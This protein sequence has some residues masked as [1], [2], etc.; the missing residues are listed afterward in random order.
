MVDQLPR[1]DDI[2]ELRESVKLLE[3]RV[4]QIERERGIAVLQPE[5]L[6]IT[7]PLTFPPVY[8]GL[9]AATLFTRVAILSFVLMGALIL[10]VLTERHILNSGF[11]TLLG[12]VYAVSLIILALLPGR[13]G[14]LARATSIFQCCGVSLAFCIALESSLR[15]HTFGR[16]MAMALIAG[17][18]ALTLVVS[19]FMRKPFLAAMTLVGSTL[20]LVGLGLESEGLWPQFVLL[21]ALG[22]ATIRLSWYHGWGFLRPLIL[23]PLLFLLA[24]GFWLARQNSLDCGPLLTS[25]ILLWIAIV[26]QHAGAFRRLNWSATLWLPLATAWLA[27]LAWTGNSQWAS[28]GAAAVSV[29]AVGAL[30]MTT[31]RIPV[32]KAGAA[33]ITVTAA[34]AG[35]PGW[36]SLD[37]S[38]VLCALVGV[39]LWLAAD[40]ERPPWAVGCT[41]FLLAASAIH[42]TIH[43]IDPHA[44]MSSV[45]AGM[46]LASILLLYYLSSECAVRDTSPGLLNF[47]SPVILVAAL[48]V[49]LG[50]LRTC[51]HR[52]FQDQSAFQLSQTALLNAS[53]LVLTFWGH[54]KR[55]PSV[56]YIGL[57]CMVAS[58]VKV[59]L[60]DMVLMRLSGIPLIAS[61]VLL[62]LS[63]VAV[64]VILHRRF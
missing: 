58:L 41:V 34:V 14:G 5:P 64:S 35:A 24:G 12:F 22:V 49:L 21:A 29:L 39:S 4:T 37:A 23:L 44:P 31:R 54:A 42:G 19:S 53:A 52:L 3:A 10:R 45:V 1:Q 20:A 47:L 27:G 25:A 40:R 50:V 17:F 62:G 18:A 26:L 57:T 32:A 63:S 6:S 9:T 2:A 7:Q 28:Y 46:I 51:A 61:L 16:P 43:E 55:R 30:A 33:G 38:G 11:G 15:L 36:L 13:L 8:S 48:L 60:N 59:G 56:T